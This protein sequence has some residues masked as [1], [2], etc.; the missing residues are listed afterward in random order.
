MPDLPY[1]GSEE[2]HRRQRFPVQRLRGARVGEPP[3][4]AERQHSAGRGLSREPLEA[5]LAAVPQNFTC[6]N[7]LP[8]GNWVHT[9]GHSQRVTWSEA[10]KRT[11]VLNAGG[12]CLQVLLLNV[13][14]AY[15][16]SVPS[17]CRTLPSVS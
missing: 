6:P 15:R 16:H 14:G 4:K 12:N 10:L 9:R 11:G 17:V 8:A 13:A 7:L 2:V 5:M 1:I 3:G